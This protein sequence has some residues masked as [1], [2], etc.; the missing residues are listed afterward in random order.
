MEE[1][2]VRKLIQGRI[3]IESDRLVIRQFRM[4]DMFKFWDYVSDE[5]LYKYLICSRFSS[6]DKSDT[7]VMNIVLS[8]KQSDLTRFAIADRNTDELV[9][10]ISAY[11]K[12]YGSYIEIEL[13][14]WIGREYQGRGYMSE[15]LKAMIDSIEDIDGL[16]AIRADI[17]K[18]N[19]ASMKLVEKLGFISDTMFKVI[20]ANNNERNAIRYLRRI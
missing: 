16:R 10:A 11:I 14:Y 17:L 12:N 2:K 6:R 13:G 19:K 20:D 7:F 3:P 1:L 4:N 5:E 18:E 15:A 8:Y 9:G